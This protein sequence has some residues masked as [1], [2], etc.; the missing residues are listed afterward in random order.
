MKVAVS[1]PQPQPSMV[2]NH[3][4][5]A[6]PQ[7]PVV[8]EDETPSPLVLKQEREEERIPGDMVCP[9]TLPLMCDPVV[10][11]DGFTYEREAIQ[12]YIDYAIHSE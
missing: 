7:P 3:E 5:D 9:I 10:A 2:V 1:S 6:P 4:D 8:D 12:Q 11:M